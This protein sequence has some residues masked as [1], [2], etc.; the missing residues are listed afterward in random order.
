M[1]PALAARRLSALPQIAAWLLS[2]GFGFEVSACPPGMDMGMDMP[3]S[4]QV[5]PAMGDDHGGMGSGMDCPFGGSMDDEGRA[6]CPFAVGGIGPCGTSTTAPAALATDI[7]S[8]PLAVFGY[9]SAVSEHTDFFESVRHP[10]P[11]A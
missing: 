2:L 4:L 1:R 6:G 8:M 10:P 7:R 11:R 9:V 5:A 3:M